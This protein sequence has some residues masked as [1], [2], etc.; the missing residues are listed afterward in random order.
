MINTYNAFIMPFN[1]RQWKC[2]E[3]YKFVSVGTADWKPAESDKNYD[4]VLGILMDTRYIID[5]YTK[6]NSSEIVKL[7]NLI[8]ESLDN[9]LKR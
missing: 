3:P 1:A 5:T 6:H 9:Y 2:E 8:D 7:A 4:Y